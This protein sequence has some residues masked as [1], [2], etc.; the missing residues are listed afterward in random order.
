MSVIH[1]HHDGKDFGSV[2]LRAFGWLGAA[3]KT[4]HQAIVA[5]KLERIENELV[6]RRGY[7]DDE[8]WQHEAVRYPQR[9]LVLSDKWD[10]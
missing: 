1:L 8:T 4:T 9:P 6:L 10:F 3:V 5:A 2:V 7:S